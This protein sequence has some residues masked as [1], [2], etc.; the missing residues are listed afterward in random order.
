MTRRAMHQMIVAYMPLV[1][2]EAIK[3]R[4]K[5]PQVA[6]EDLRSAGYVGLCQAASRLDPQRLT[7]FGPFAR[8]R[9]RGAI[10][11]ANK[12]QQYREAQHVSLDTVASNY[13]GEDLLRVDHPNDLPDATPLPDAQAEQSERE[14]AVALLISE[15]PAQE[16]ALMRALM[17]GM[18]VTDAS[19]AL[20]MSRA[21]GRARMAEMRDRIGAGMI[22]R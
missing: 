14:Q 11:D 20:G 9:I 6:L 15:L 16:S 18:S 21:W 4:P 19:K 7:Y 3:L 2:S 1:H 22:L 8:Y 5:F 17:A 10:I 12:R 13:Y